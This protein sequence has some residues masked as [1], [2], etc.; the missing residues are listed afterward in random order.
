MTSPSHKGARPVGTDAGHPAV[1]F[2]PMG[3]CPGL[4][5]APNPASP[6]FALASR[7]ANQALSRQVEIAFD[8]GRALKAQSRDLARAADMTVPPGPWRESLKQVALG[9][10][11]LADWFVA[12]AL[13][14]GRRFGGLAFA[15][16]LPGRTP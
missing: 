3:A 10:D 5:L 2:A 16:P 6:T 8:V 9:Q 7:T 12:Q 15:R 14:Y 4:G 1:S 11:S 13:D